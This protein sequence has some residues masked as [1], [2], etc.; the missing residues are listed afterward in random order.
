MSNKTNLSTVLAIAIVESTHFFNKKLPD[1]PNQ[2][3]SMK[4]SYEKIAKEA[5]VLLKAAGLELRPT[6]PTE[7][8][9]E[10]GKS[11]PMVRSVDDNKSYAEMVYDSMFRN[12]TQ[13]I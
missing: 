8:M 11:V 2:P 13:E 5:L 7:N 1:W 10:S 6:V 4:D 9:I 3:E 12:Y